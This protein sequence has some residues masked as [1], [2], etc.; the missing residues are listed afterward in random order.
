MTKGYAIERWTGKSWCPSLCSPYKT[1]SE[2]N[3]HLKDYFWHYTNDNPY[4]IVD[5][6]SKKKIQRYSPKYNFLE[7][8][9]DKGMVFSITSGSR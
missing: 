5:Y 3:K 6:K 4:R 2:V 9:S 1:M 8:N 7:W